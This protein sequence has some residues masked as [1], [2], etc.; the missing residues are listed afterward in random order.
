[1]ERK[2]GKGWQAKNVTWL[3]SIPLD[4]LHI[5]VG[6]VP[7]PPPVPTPLHAAEVYNYKREIL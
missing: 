2:V 7:P 1:M 4:S 5:C 6:H 3:R